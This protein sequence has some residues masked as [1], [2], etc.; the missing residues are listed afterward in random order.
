MKLEENLSTCLP[1]NEKVCE[2]EGINNSGFDYIKKILYTK[3]VLQWKVKCSGKAYDYQN[4]LSEE[5][6][7]IVIKIL[8]KPWLENRWRS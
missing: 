5:L 1:L 7:S 6:M 2:S 4:K 8:L 3:N